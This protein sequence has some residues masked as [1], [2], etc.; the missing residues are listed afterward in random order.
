MRIATVDIGTNTLLLLITEHNPATGELEALVDECRFGRLG[1]GVD[2]NGRLATEAVTRCV[3]ICREY[4]SILAKHA[5]LDRVRVVGT[6]ALREADNALA[7]VTAAEQLLG[8]TIDIISGVREAE[9]VQIAT[10]ASLPAVRA[11][12]Y[13]VAD[14]GGGSTEF[15]VGGA[16][17]PSWRRSLPIGSV[18]LT[19][20]FLP[21]HPA[22]PDHVS[23]LMAAIDTSLA[24]LSLPQGVRVIGSAGTATTIVSVELRLSSYDP[25]QV[26]GRSISRAVLERQ[27]ARFLESSIAERK[28]IAGLA[29]ER[30]DVIAAGAAIYARLLAQTSA[31][32][33]MV[34]DRGVRW[35]LAY[36]AVAVA[37]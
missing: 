22:T 35:G 9:L 2:A 6:Q 17:T 37:G 14:V 21:D 34:S 31:P 18:R 27:L 29:P 28:Q 19:E 8:A 20:K 4:Q 1:Q 26:H 25:S 15:I 11:S 36:E 12:P 10:E 7:F 13:I 30:A 33:I 16:G 23:A 3:D 32:E 5:P 24:T